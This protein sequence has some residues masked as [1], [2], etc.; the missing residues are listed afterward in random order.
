MR[1]GKPIVVLFHIDFSLAS[2]KYLSEGTKKLTITVD[3]KI[4]YSVE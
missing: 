4:I 1:F 3:E 2:K